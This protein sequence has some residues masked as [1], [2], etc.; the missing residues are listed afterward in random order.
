MAIIVEDGTAKTDAV[1]YLS[2]TDANTH[3]TA[4]GNT[5]WSALSDANKETALVRATDYIDK[6]F[7]RKFRGH[8]I[9]S[10]QALEWPR[11]A[12]TDNDGFAIGSGEVPSQLKK[13]TAEYAMRAYL[14]NVLAPD[15]PAP[16]PSQSWVTGVSNGSI[17]AT[18]ELQ[19][20]KV[21]AGDV[22]SEKEYTSPSGPFTMPAKSTLVSSRAIP[23]YP[24]ADLWLEE[25]IR[26]SMSIPIYRA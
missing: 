10:A 7:G 9:S 16:V 14:Y 4:R 15:V 24:E 19:R 22:M 11:S 3:H 17:P 1:S 8:K 26:S 12:A 13:A 21:Q 18:G 5:Q 20:T 6:R 23:E 2:V 25:L